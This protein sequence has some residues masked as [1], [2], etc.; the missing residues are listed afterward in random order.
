MECIYMNLC[1]TPVSSYAKV[2]VA[3]LCFFI[4]KILLN[5][6]YNFLLIVGK[7]FVA[8]FWT[9]YGNSNSPPLK[10]ARLWNEMNLVS[11]TV[12]NVSKYGV[13]S[14]P[15][16]P[17]FGLNTEIR[18]IFPYSVRM[19]ENTE[20]KKVPYLD[21][22]HAVITDKEKS[23]K[24]FRQERTPQRISTGFIWTNRKFS[25]FWE[26]TYFLRLESLALLLLLPFAYHVGKWIIY[27]KMVFCFFHFFPHSS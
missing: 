11:F 10:S 27:R 23:L 3:P 25:H 19:R 21:T 18:S 16:F 15:Y 17:A 13:F 14:V 6:R 24:S 26:K 4:L 22:F 7:L 5:T 8:V 20:Q 12:W 9:E 1:R 2:F